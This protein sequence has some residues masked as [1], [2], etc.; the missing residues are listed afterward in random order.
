MTPRPAPVQAVAF[1]ARS[2]DVEMTTV[3]G[4]NIFEH[5]SCTRLDE[6]GAMEEARGRASDLIK[7]L[8]LP[9]H[10]DPSRSS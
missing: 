1:A 9:A 2:A 3:G 7:R 6:T 8:D 4:E 10:I 5:G